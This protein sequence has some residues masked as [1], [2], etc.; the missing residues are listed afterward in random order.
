[1]SKINKAGR[2][3]NAGI[4][5]IKQNLLFVYDQCA[6]YFFITRIRGTNYGHELHEFCPF[7][8]EHLI[9]VMI[10]SFDLFREFIIN[11]NLCIITDFK[12]RVIRLY[13]S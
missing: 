6:E 1:V 9:M 3:P 13:N 5:N 2:K 10:K 8:F 11:R 4:V 12:I 7:K